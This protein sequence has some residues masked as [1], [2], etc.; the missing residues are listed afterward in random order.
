MDHYDTFVT[1]ASW[2]L[3]HEAPTAAE[4]QQW[5]AQARTDSTGA[6]S[7]IYQD[8]FA[9]SRPAR[10]QVKLLYKAALGDFTHEDPFDLDFWT[11]L[12]TVNKDVGE[13]AASF[14]DIAT[15]GF[16]TDP[17]GLP[18]DPTRKFQ[19]LA[20]AADDSWSSPTV[21]TRISTA[22]ARAAP[23]RAAG[24]SSISVPWWTAA[25]ARTSSRIVYLRC[26]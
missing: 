9:T 17:S 21:R 1:D 14:S 26:N 13:L 23:R 5:S 12:Y 24:S 10:E 6:L 20:G 4:L 7:A 22:S 3:R 16:R 11:S 8:S 2:I 19:S 15:S 25:R 18:V